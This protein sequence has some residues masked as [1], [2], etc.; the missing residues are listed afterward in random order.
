MEQ[1][2][3]DHTTWYLGEGQSKFS[4][5][6]IGCDG[7]ETESVRSMVNLF[8]Q[9]CVTM[10]AEDLLS[11]L[12]DDASDESRTIVYD[13]KCS[14]NVEVAIKNAGGIPQMSRIHSFASAF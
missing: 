4:D 10:F 11:N 7:M 9:E 13:V 6:G 5:F 1:T 2:Q 3:Q 12:D 8:T 14:M